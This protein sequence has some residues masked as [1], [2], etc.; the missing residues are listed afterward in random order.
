MSFQN[1]VT[2]T[3]ELVATSARGTLM[4]NRGGRFHRADKTLSRRRWAS[5]AWITCRLE[6]NNR[7][8]EIMSANSYTE[9]FF[10]DE[11]TALAA[12]HRPC[13]ECR[14]ADAVSFAQYWHASQEREPG[15]CGAHRLRARAGAMD[16]VLHEQRR[17]PNGDKKTHKMSIGALPGGTIINWRGQ[18]HLLSS[19]RLWQWSL[20][21]YQ[22]SKF[23]TGAFLRGETPVDV[24]TPPA[25]VA[26]L[27]LGYAPQLHPSAQP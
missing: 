20:E 17:L 9:L 10:L 3:G 21:G 5:R 14:R 26:V 18:P 23:P 24:L 25:I 6:F 2:P 4:G 15:G 11:A 13:F 7:H 27:S 16:K 1:R 8:R 19:Q 22:P 12:G